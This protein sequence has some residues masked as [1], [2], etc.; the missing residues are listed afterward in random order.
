MTPAHAAALA[1]V[2]ALRLLPRRL[3]WSFLLRASA[4]AA[5][6]LRAAGV[7]PG[8][9]IDGFREIALWRLM[10]AAGEAGLAFD[11]VLEHCGPPPLDGAARP[12]GGMLVAGPHSLLNYLAVRHLHD[13][14]GDP[15]V[16]AADPTIPVF[17][18]RTV[19]R[20]VP[21]SLTLLPQA[22]RHFRAGDVVC[23]MIDWPEAAKGTF[24]V[25]T[26]LGPIHV[27]EP[28]LK[29]AVAAD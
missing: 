2:Y 13:R 22:A 27:A 15:V 23:A 1:V 8:M 16:V 19:P 26:A 28:L 4:V 5:P 24:R 9:G 14:G 11:P 7:E 20:A 12:R 21:A 25:E 29:L 3:R 17:G 10:V 18:T 6:I